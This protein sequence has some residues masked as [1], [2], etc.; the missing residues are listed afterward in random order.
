MIQLTVNL[1]SSAKMLGTEPEALLAFVE[2]E[3]LEGVFKL[4]GDWRVSIFTLARLLNTTP[5]T[6]LDLLEDYT[7]GQMIEEVEDDEYV[8]TQEGWATYQAVLAEAQK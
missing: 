1:E 8:G 4:N 5:Q 6:L 2:R 7:L 3:Q